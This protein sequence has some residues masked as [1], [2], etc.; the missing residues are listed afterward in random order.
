[1]ETSE[2]ELDGCDDPHSHMEG[3][4]LVTPKFKE[5][6]EDR[7]ECLKERRK[8]SH[9]KSMAD[10]LAQESVFSELMQMGCV[11]KVRV[12]KSSGGSKSGNT[13]EC[14]CGP[15]MKDGKPIRP[16]DMVDC[17]TLCSMHGLPMTKTKS[18]DCWNKDPKKFFA[19]VIRHPECNPRSSQEFA[20]RHNEKPSKGCNAN[21]SGGS[22]SVE[23]SQGMVDLRDFVVSSAATESEQHVFS[24]LNL[25]HLIACAKDRVEN[26]AHVCDKKND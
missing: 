4:E 19:S 25:S 8:A 23:G 13:E 11:A 14:I 1:M 16:G 17:H 24:A 10:F 5:N 12:K 18:G 2:M 6:D 20:L 7:T 22:A 26:V 21:A 15:P 9:S 3:S